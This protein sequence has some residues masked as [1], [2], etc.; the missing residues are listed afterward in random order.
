[1]KVLATCVLAVVI[2]TGFITMTAAEGNCSDATPKSGSPYSITGGT[3]GLSVA[4]ESAKSGPSDRKA[5]DYQQHS[6]RGLT[7][8]QRLEL[9]RDLQIR[10]EPAG[11]EN[12]PF[13]LRHY[14]GG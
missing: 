8:E 2:A 10:I 6:I 5:G 9:Q 1:M 14:T 13:S 11:P 7:P 3:T 12:Y 4:D